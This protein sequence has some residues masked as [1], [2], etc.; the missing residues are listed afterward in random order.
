MILFLP[1]SLP[2]ATPIGDSYAMQTRDGF[3][4]YF[5]NLQPFDCHPAD[6]RPRHAAPRR[7][8]AR[9]FRRSPS[10]HHVRLRHLA[11]H[12]G[13]RRQTLSRARRRR[14]FRAAPGA[15]AYRRRRRDGRPSGQTARFR[16]QRQR[17]RSATRHSGEHLPRKPSRRRLR[18]P[19][20]RHLP[21][22]RTLRRRLRPPITPPTRTLR[23]RLRSP[24]T[25]PTLRTP[26]RLRPPIAPPATPATSTRPWAA[27]LV[28]SR[29]ACSPAPA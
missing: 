24:I 26:T 21:P 1:F 2:D 3:T 15:W 27:R 5:F 23:R 19:R 4:Y 8:A 22:S 9:R 28:T 29:A 18:C 10:R 13:T 7:Q 11:P 16:D 25:P 20:R 6:D 14:L 12:R 17:L